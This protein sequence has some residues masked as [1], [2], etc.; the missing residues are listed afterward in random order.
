MSAAE[1]RRVKVLTPKAARVRENVLQLV[2]ETAAEGIYEFRVTEAEVSAMEASCVVTITTGD[3]RKKVKDVGSKS[4]S[5]KTS[6]VRILMP[7]GMVW[8]DDSNFTGSI[9]D[10]ESITRYNSDTGL[11][12]KEYRANHD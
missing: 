11:V 6:L 3:K 4:L 1:A 5:E 7:E 9:E 10:S 2:I 8:E 12:W